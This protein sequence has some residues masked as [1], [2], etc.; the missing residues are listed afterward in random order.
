MLRF[1]NGSKISDRISTESILT[2][3]NLLSVNQLNAQI[4]ILEIWKATH[5]NQYPAKITKLTIR[6]NSPSTRAITNGNL[7]EKGISILS[8]NTYLND[9]I[10]AWNLIP[11]DIKNCETIWSAK[12]SIKNF[13]KTLPI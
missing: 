11:E 13:V 6:N 12:K 4:K 2:K 8:K 1:L 7:V 9:A 10:R 3:Y 5:I